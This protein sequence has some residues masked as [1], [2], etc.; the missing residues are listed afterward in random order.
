MDV[1][2]NHTFKQ[3]SINNRVNMDYTIVD[4]KNLVTS[5]YNEFLPEIVGD[6][7]KAMFVQNAGIVYL[8]DICI[9]SIESASCKFLVRKVIGMS[10][11]GNIN[12]IIRE[13]KPVNNIHLKQFFNLIET[14]NKIDDEHRNKLL[15]LANRRYISTSRDVLMS[16]SKEFDE[17]LDKMFIFMSKLGLANTRFYSSES[18]GFNDICDVAKIFFPKSILSFADQIEGN[19]IQISS[20]NDVMIPI[21]IKLMSGLSTTPTQFIDKIRKSTLLDFEKLI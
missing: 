12:I 3:E 2:C 17:F 7:D 1:Y 19:T 18:L 5:W 8:N 14:T 6:D 9:S 16:Q 11:H 4:W 21:S 10:R 15:H 20:T 13:S